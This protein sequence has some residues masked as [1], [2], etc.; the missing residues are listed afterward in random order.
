MLDLTVKCT[1]EVKV[2]PQVA[3]TQVVLPP[4]TVAHTGTAAGTSMAFVSPPAPV[5]EQP[6]VHA[7]GFP[8]LRLV[9]SP[10]YTSVVRMVIPVSLA[11]AAVGSS[12]SLLVTCRR[13]FRPTVYKRGPH[14]MLRTRTVCSM[15]HRFHQDSSFGFLGGADRLRLEGSYCR[16]RWMTLMIR[17]W[18]IR[19][20]M[21]GV[22]IFRGQN[23]HCRSLCTRGR[24]VWPFYWILRYVRLCWLRC[25]PH[26]RRRGPQPLPLL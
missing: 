20:P 12:W 25:P 5:V 11:H 21:R 8:T 22:N 2:P 14:R 7:K 19:S 9:E 6:G 24:Q 10:E 13:P 1:S 23:P 15:C 18:V 16:R 4:A 3:S 17:F 26:C